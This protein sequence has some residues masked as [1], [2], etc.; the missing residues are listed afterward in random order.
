MLSLHICAHGVKYS[1]VLTKQTNKQT[2][3]SL[4]THTICFLY[5]RESVAFTKWTCNLNVFKISKLRE[6]LHRIETATG[7]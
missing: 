6:N 5:Y 1:L 2:N 3:Q 4:I 7:S